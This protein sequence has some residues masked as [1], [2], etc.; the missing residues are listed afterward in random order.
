MNPKWLLWSSVIA[1]IGVVAGVGSFALTSLLVGGRFASL[2]AGFLTVVV[3][4]VVGGRF[5]PKNSPPGHDYVHEGSGIWG[6]QAW[7]MG[8]WLSC[9]NGRGLTISAGAPCRRL[10]SARCTMVRTLATTAGS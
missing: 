2:T 1:M 4:D 5:T 9:P 8:S 7:A 10:C 3:V 6:R